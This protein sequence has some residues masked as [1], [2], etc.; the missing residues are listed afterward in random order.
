MTSKNTYRVG[1]DGTANYS[2]LSAIPSS[3]LAQGDNTI[4]VYPGTYTAPTDAVWNDVALVGVGDREEIV[5]SGGMTI[6][7]TSAGILSFENIS[8]VGANAAVAAA[9]TCV[10]KLGASSTPLHFRNCSFSNAKHAVQHQAT[11]AV[12]TT[13]QQVVMTYCDASSVDQAIV[14]NANV[15][16]NWSAMNASANA[17]FQPGTGGGAASLTVTVR[18]S[19]SGG[20][21][22]GNNTETV[23]ALI[24]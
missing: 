6:A 10:T 3:I 18:A 8:F 2:S 15:G 7:N 5:I 22:T 14:A 9:A 17:Y 11:L 24:S 13:T 20:S 21:N 23:L 16:I 4:L 1:T 19:T 12:A